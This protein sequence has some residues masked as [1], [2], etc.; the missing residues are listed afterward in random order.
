MDWY[1]VDEMAQG[2]GMKKEARFAQIEPLLRTQMSFI[3]IGEQLGVSRETVR[4]YAA[5]IGIKGRQRN[6]EKRIIKLRETLSDGRP[7][8]PH[9]GGFLARVGVGKL[10]NMRYRCKQCRKFSFYGDKTR[11]SKTRD[12]D[13]YS[14]IGL[15]GCT[16]RWHGD[17]PGDAA[18]GWAVRHLYY[19]FSI[20]TLKSDDLV[21]R[22]NAL[23]RKSLPESIRADVCQE[24][25]CA[26]LEG[27]VKE[28]SL[29]KTVIETF[30]KEQFKGLG[31]FISLDEL[32]DG[33]ERS[34]GEKI[35]VY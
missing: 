29:D 28:S 26:I 20:P 19:P 9:C 35:G 30:I 14:R 16:V 24:I 13:Y 32:R 17:K 31:W 23:V 1:S 5:S 18:S 7:P 10:G 21:L 25:L 34:F 27:K 8:C 2:K 4:Q 6:Y 12:S 33:D 22:V 11:E 15:I 3:E